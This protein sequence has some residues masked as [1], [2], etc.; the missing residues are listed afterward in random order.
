MS[1]FHIF[2]ICTVI[3]GLGIKIYPS[4]LPQAEINKRYNFP[5]IKAVENNAQ[6]DI[7]KLIDEIRTIPEALRYVVSWTVMLGKIDIIKILIDKKAIRPQAA[8]NKRQI[9]AFN[10]FVSFEKDDYNGAINMAINTAIGCSTPCIC[11]LALA[12]TMLKNDF[13]DVATSEVNWVVKENSVIM[14]LLESPLW[15]IFVNLEQD[16]VIFLPEEYSDELLANYGLSPKLTYIKPGEFSKFIDKHPDFQRRQVKLENFKKLFNELTD[17]PKRFILDGHGLTNYLIASIP[18]ERFEMVLKL[19]L[20]IDTQFLYIRTCYGGGINLIKTQQFLQHIIEKNEHDRLMKAYEYKK[21]ERIGASPAKKELGCAIVME[22]TGEAMAFTMLNDPTAFFDKLNIYLSDPHWVFGRSQN[23]TLATVVQAI[24]INLPS[25]LCSIRLPGANSFFDSVNFGKMTII[26][27]FGLQQNRVQRLVPRAL[28]S[29]EKLQRLQT[30]QKQLAIKTQ[31]EQLRLHAENEQYLEEIDR[32]R[33]EIASIQETQTVLLE[34]FRKL[35]LLEQELAEKKGPEKKE[36]E[37]QINDAKTEIAKFKLV[38]SDISITIPKSSDKLLVYPTNLT[39]VE[40]KIEGKIPHIISKISSKSMHFIKSMTLN[41]QQKTVIGI[42]T[43]EFIG[44]DFLRGVGFATLLGNTKK[45][46]FIENLFIKLQDGSNF[47]IHGVCIATN[48][49]G[50][51]ACSLADL[52]Y[53]ILYIE[54]GAHKQM[55][56][57]PHECEAQFSEISLAEY[58]NKLRVIFEIYRADPAALFEATRG[59]ETS[60]D[61][62]EAF[63]IFAQRVLGKT[64]A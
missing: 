15:S 35:A 59:H 23:M 42:L 54:N 16:M 40:F 41:S 29:P 6:A 37:K 27:W 25:N 33:A 20:D 19:L 1:R 64:I 26:T 51:N 38:L 48:L 58:E 12:Y 9:A 44:E 50:R 36:I 8:K 18:I 14:L 10:A 62:K 24:S 2:I 39:D 31:P 49:L 34:N 56:K 46:W 7:D 28:L 21:S 61:E 30:L 22:A 60:E 57:T 45:A 17:L 53:K 47:V 3:L 43:K 63:D 5:L 11:S 52:D 32:I 55:Y 13:H 4:E